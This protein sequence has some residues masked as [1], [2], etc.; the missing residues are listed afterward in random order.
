LAQAVDDA[1]TRTSFGHFDFDSD[2]AAR[3]ASMLVEMLA[4]RSATAAIA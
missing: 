2:G 1:G 3:T 4:A